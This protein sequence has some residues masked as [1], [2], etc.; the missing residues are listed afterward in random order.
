[1]KL[2][3]DGWISKVILILLWG[4][5]MSSQNVLLEHELL[6]IL[7]T[8][9]EDALVGTAI[10]P[11]VLANP[12]G[13]CG[14]YGRDTGNLNLG[15]RFCEV[16][17]SLGGCYNISIGGILV[18]GTDELVII[19]LNG[20]TMFLKH[21]RLDDISIERNHFSTKMT[22]MFAGVIL[23]GVLSK[24]DLVLLK[25]MVIEIIG[26]SNDGGFANLTFSAVSIGPIV[27]NS[28]EV[29]RFVDGLGSS[30][31]HFPDNW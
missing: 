14:G 22:F 11:M 21:M 10:G 20:D 16:G 4:H 3:D 27:N 26:I 9:T 28:R 8:L 24:R 23:E 31:S 25:K 5:V 6:W 15:P 1:M 7:L 19:V 12:D 17:A 13:A 18:G 29:F 30:Y 2:F